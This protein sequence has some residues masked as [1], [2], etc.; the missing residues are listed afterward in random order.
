MSSGFRW[1]RDALDALL[2]I[3]ISGSGQR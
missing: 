3:A 2:Q 1:R